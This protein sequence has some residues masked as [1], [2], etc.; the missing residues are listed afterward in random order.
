MSLLPGTKAPNFTGK[1]YQSGYFSSIRDFELNELSGSWVVLFFYPMDFG[2]IAASELLELEKVARSLSY[3]GCSIIG[4]SG[5]SV[6]VHEQFVSLKAKHGG[7][8]GIS[9]P[10]LADV[11]GDIR[12]EY[13]MLRTGCGYNYRGYYIVSP[14]GLV[15]GRTVSDLPVGIYAGDILD[16]VQCLVRAEKLGIEDPSVLENRVES[17]SSPFDILRGNQEYYQTSVL[18][19]SDHHNHKTGLQQSPINIASGEATTDDQLSPLKIT[20]TPPWE[21]NNDHSGRQ[22]TIVRNTGFG[23]DIPVNEEWKATVKE[24]PL[25]HHTYRL[26]L[27]RAL[28]GSSE[29]SIDGKFYQGELHFELF[30]TRYDNATEAYNH[31]DGYAI[32]SVFIKEDEEEYNKEIKKIVDVL[33]LIE[34]RGRSTPTAVPVSFKNLLPKSRDYFSYR[35]SLTTPDFREIVDWIVMVEPISVSKACIATMKKLSYGCTTDK[36]MITNV[37]SQFGRGD[38]VVHKAVDSDTATSS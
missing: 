13:G 19:Q 37:R 29:H 4:I 18:E 16:Q 11:N 7:A 1:I 3:L 33:P 36:C 2:H 8:S 23:W 6:L 28:W 17:I 27:L 35:G 10:L 26:F 25:G 22:P 32:I 20:F 31:A 14:K 5:D 38:R 15:K 9:F 24:G 34:E 30:N 12:R 21:E